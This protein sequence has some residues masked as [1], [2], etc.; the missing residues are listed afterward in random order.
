MTTKTTYASELGKCYNKTTDGFYRLYKADGL[1]AIYL[2]SKELIWDTDYNFTEGT[3]LQA[4]LGGYIADPENFEIGVEAIKE[5][6]DALAREFEM[7][8]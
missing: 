3:R 1:W 7:F 8:G 2:V 5:E 4:T 6:A